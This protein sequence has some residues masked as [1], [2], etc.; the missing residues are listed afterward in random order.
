MNIQ[1]KHT[2]YYTAFD[3]RARRLIVEMQAAAQDR[4]TK[5]LMRRGT[6]ALPGGTPE[7]RRDATPDAADL[8]T[9]ERSSRVESHTYGTRYFLT[10]CRR[11]DRHRVAH[12]SDRLGSDRLTSS[13]D[14]RTRRQTV[15][16]CTVL[17]CTVLYAVNVA[18]S[19]AA[20][21]GCDGA[22]CVDAIFSAPSIRSPNYGSLHFPRVLFACAAAPPLA[23]RVSGLF[24]PHLFSS[25]SATRASPKRTPSSTCL[26]V[27]TISSS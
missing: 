8:K 24:L 10:S 17:Y 3:T 11:V 6:R 2:G 15:L 25:L 14:V 27:C 9:T 26:Y 4:S 5:R 7:T 22:I 23:S 19:E 13:S 18:G 21:S 12:R 1:Y 20:A 16:Y